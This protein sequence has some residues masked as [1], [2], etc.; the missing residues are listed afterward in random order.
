MDMMKPSVREAGP[1][2]PET[3]E[4]GAS[5]VPPPGLLLETVHLIF[6]PSP[7]H[8]T[9]GFAR[10]DLSKGMLVIEYVGE[11]I[12]KSQSAERCRQGNE[13]IFRLDDETDLDGNVAW[14]PARFLN[15][16]CAPNCEAE[17]IDG[18][19]WIV[20]LREIKVGEEITFDYGYDL[21]DYRQHPCRC[22]APDCAGYIVA[23]ELRSSVRAG[24]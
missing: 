19:I 23:A 1:A 4:P 22:G 20:A 18:K 14:N 8:G 6:K 21:E 9:G 5:G 24:A 11:I 16:S 17:L 13:Y 2:P 10:R 15:H 7:I 3:A 12:T